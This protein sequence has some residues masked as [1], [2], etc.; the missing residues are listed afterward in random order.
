M[1]EITFFIGNGFDINVGLATRYSDFYKYFIEQFPDNMIALEI[2]KDY[3]YWS[4]LEVALGKYTSKI[5]LGR[6]ED[7]LESEDILEQSL[8]DYLEMQMN[9]IS[10]DSNEKKEEIALMMKKSLLQFPEELPKEHQQ[11][12]NSL[13]SHTPEEIA[14]SFISFN[15]TN[16]LDLCIETTKDI[17]P[18]NL[19]TH[20]VNGYDFSH[21]IHNALHI[22]GTTTEEL[23]LG[24]NDIDQI[25]N[26][27]FVNNQ[28]YRLCLVKEEANKR[29]GQNKIQD[30]RSMIDRSMI[31]CVFGM[32]IGSTDKM[33][34]EYIGKWLIESEKRRLIIY[35]KRNNLLKRVTKRALFSSQNEILDRFKV[36]V[37]L[38]DGEWDKISQQIYIK[39]DS[40]VFSFKLTAD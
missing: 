30:A 29:F 26:K 37:A 17:F 35:V 16:A 4:D 27:E 14:Y 8:A 34:W 32:S 36:N 6:E 7:F 20:R 13:I 31:I 11:Y 28:F 2:G 23:I 12:I 33:W 15:Y 10:I 25:D 40:D 5:T 24:V 22:H 18:K 3:E 39:Y 21:Y 19:G 1:K 38:S 9:Q